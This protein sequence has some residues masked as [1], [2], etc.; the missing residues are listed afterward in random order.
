[1]ILYYFNYLFPVSFGFA[2]FG[3]STFGDSDMEK[4]IGDGFYK[5]S[6]YAKSKYPQNNPIN[7]DYKKNQVPKLEAAKKLDPQKEAQKVLIQDNTK[8]KKNSSSADQQ[9]NKEN[10]TSTND[11]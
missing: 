2:G 10:S 11:F 5:I 1:M 3:L 4:E 6:E 9:R 7:V 8:T